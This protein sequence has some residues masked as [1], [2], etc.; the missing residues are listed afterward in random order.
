MSLVQYSY[1]ANPI[2][3]VKIRICFK[4]QEGKRAL[5]VIKKG[6]K[7]QKVLD[8]YHLSQ[9]LEYNTLRFITPEGDRMLGSKTPNDA[10]AQCKISLN[11]LAVV[12]E[13]VDDTAGAA[14][15]EDVEEFNPER[16]SGGVSKATKNPISF[17]P[18]DWGPRICLGQSFALIESKMAIAMILQRFSFE[19]SSTYVHAPYTVITL[20]PQHGAQLI[21]HKL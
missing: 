3:D 5:F 13:S 20:Q 7:L 6:D 14:Q 2:D 11:K 15:G 4:D 1:N 12:K 19:L 16:F 9:S 21:V 17:F 10:L 8:E 18:F